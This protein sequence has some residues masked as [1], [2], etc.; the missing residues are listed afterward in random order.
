MDDIAVL[1]AAQHVYHSVY[2][3]DVREEFVAES[4]S[5]GGSLDQ[6][7]NI[8]KFDDSGRIQLWMVHF[9]KLVKP[10]IRYLYHADVRIDGAEGIIRTGR[11]RTGKCVE[12]GAFSYIW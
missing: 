9:G 1:K 4:L 6:S 3:A 5:F 7:R 8:D 2:I 11:T 12:K 10:R